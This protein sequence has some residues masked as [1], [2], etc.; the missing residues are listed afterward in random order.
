MEESGAKQDTDPQGETGGGD[1]PAGKAEQTEEQDTEAR[2]ED[3]TQ[4]SP[5]DDE[6]TKARKAEEKRDQAQDEVKEWEQKDA[7]EL[8]TDLD[9]WPSGAAKYETFGG[10]E[11]EES[12]EESVTSKLG[13]S[14]LRHKE[15][16]GVEIEG[17]EVDNPEEY[18]GGPIP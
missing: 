12:Y 11:G 8:P 1:T 9:E 2:G 15:D 17:E 18:K 13:P 4:A 16:G 6:A 5:D 3:D 7:D 10:P 14:S